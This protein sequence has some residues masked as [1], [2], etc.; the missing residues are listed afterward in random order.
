ME[1]ATAIEHVE[2]VEQAPVVWRPATKLGFRLA[3]VLFSLFIFPFPV[4]NIPYVSKISGLYEKLWRAIVPWVGKHVLRIGHDIVLVETGSGDTTW[5]W[6]QAFS[7]LAIAVIA[8]VVWSALDRKRP[9]YTRLY[10]WFTLVLRYSLA[11]TMFVYGLSKVFPLQMPAPM[12]RTLLE[13]YGE[14]SPMGILWTFIGASKSY[15]I[16]T[17]SVET[18]A[19]LLLIFPR[20]S[21]L[22]AMLA[23]AAMF[24]VWMLNM[25]YD[26]PVKLY[27]FLLLLEAVFLFL[28]YIPRLANLLLF[29]RPVQPRPA[30]P[31]FQRK[32]A[33]RAAIIV[34]VLF[35]L[36]LFGSTV[37]R[38]YG[39][40]KGPYGFLGTKPPLHG[41]WNVDELSIDGQIQP[42]LLSD[43]D[44]WHRLIYDF[45]KFVSV[46]PMDGPM[47][48]LPLEIDTDNKTMAFT[49]RKDPN[50]KA[51]FKYQQP[52]PE[53]LVLDG[54]IDGHKAHAK[55][56]RFDESKFLLTN[57]G[58]HWVQEFP[59]N[60]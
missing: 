46:Q 22:G 26:V 34:P 39:Q 27:S 59:F 54:E 52:S 33:N 13:P 47:D 14:A 21:T 31:F 30:G 12:L 48:Y 32:W 11:G 58:F 24:Q 6:V 5:G 55:L 16:F 49:K 4:D 17:G 20:T 23:A 37:Y 50:W 38:S 3:F 60:R 41:V 40:A 45:P 42:P 29:Q 9:N 7:I 25:C 44:R 36:Y 56:S 19:G 51:D 53:E 8:A 18:V 2:V 15:E 1:T 28:P 10:K 35:G 57:R 43:A